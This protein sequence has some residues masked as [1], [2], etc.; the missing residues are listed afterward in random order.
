[1]RI[2]A[3]TV[4]HPHSSIM[5]EKTVHSTVNCFFYEKI[6]NTGLSVFLCWLF[7]L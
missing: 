4:I 1:M 3:F 2:N 6:V 5:L 7:T